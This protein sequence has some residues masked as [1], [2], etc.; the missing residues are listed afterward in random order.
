[1]ISISGCYTATNTSYSTITHERYDEAV[2]LTGAERN[3]NNFEKIQLSGNFKSTIIPSDSSNI[4]I[5]GDDADRVLTVV[6]DEVLYVEQEQRLGF[7]TRSPQVELIIESPLE[8]TEMRLTGSNDTHLV[9]GDNLR[10]LKLSGS[11]RIKAD[12]ID[13]DSLSIRETGSSRI[14]ANGFADE[15]E[16]RLSGSS[17]IQAEHLKSEKPIIRTGG[18][19]R[20]TLFVSEELNVRSSG[21]ANVYY[22]GSPSKVETQT[23]GSSRVQPL[24]KMSGK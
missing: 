2:A 15:L 22:D 12:E 17:R 9:N 24:E 3:L 6:E 5:K 18:S 11:T 20:V 7:F 14:E 23:S 13:T 16:M 1:M 8:I 21:S 10:Y 4:T 19:S